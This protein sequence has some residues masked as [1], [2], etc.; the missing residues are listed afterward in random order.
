L[1]YCR[2]VQ[3]HAS[4]SVSRPNPDKRAIGIKEN[5]AVIWVRRATRTCNLKS[6]ELLKLSGESTTEITNL[7]A[8]SPSKNWN[9]K[10][11]ERDLRGP[12]GLPGNT[13]RRSEPSHR[14][15]ARALAQR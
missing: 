8:T 9:R 10:S 14:R 7:P 1:G 3:L 13:G 4:V 12:L 11:H 6:F 2:L 5:H 15:Q